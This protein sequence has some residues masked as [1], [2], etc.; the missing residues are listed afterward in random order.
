MLGAI[1]TC[2]L[3]FPDWELTDDVKVYQIQDTEDQGPQEEC[4]YD[5]RCKYDQ[6]QRTT[7]NSESK[8]VSLQGNIIIKGDIIIKDTDKF[9]GY[10]VVNG[11]KKDVYSL[12]K[13]KVMGYVFSTELELK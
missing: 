13:P 12:S 11:I 10:V 6:T 9:E 2:P 7:F 5:G 1:V 4:V 8:L 3:P